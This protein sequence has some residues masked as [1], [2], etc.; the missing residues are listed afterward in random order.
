MR[1]DSRGAVSAGRIQTHAGRAFGATARGSRNA[2][3]V[4]VIHK[5]PTGGA[6]TSPAHHGPG[7]SAG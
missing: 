4:G 5:I 6:A 2:P 7:P 3:C 1:H